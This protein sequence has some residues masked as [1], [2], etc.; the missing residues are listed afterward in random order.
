[1]NDF[2]YAPIADTAIRIRRTCIS[3]NGHALT[4]AFGMTGT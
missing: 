1:M 4:V 2:N 3:A